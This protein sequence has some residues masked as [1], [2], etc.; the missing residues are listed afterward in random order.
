MDL[1]ISNHIDR[2]ITG[3]ILSDIENKLTKKYNKG[4]SAELRLKDDTITV[5]I[6]DME[7]KEKETFM[8]RGE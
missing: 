1:V 2:L 5:I 8:V 3:E 4:Y 7:T 6:H